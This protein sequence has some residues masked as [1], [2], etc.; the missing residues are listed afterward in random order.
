MPITSSTYPNDN[1]IREQIATHY[2][3]SDA[4]S[5]MTPVRC[6][7]DGNCFMRSIFKLV[8]GTESHHLA[9]RVAIVFEAVIHKNYF[10]DDTY[11]SG[12]IHGANSLPSQYA[13][14]SE[15]YNDVDTSSWNSRT[16]E[17]IYEHKVV[18]LTKSGC[19]CGMWQ[20]YQA[21][22]VVERPI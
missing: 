16:L 21:A 13:I 8:F 18:S 10:L 3:P 4:P 2:Y 11:L 6:Y 5:H 14:Y 1:F 20:F 19:Y 9:V 12:E 22:N 7:G 17:D 15:S